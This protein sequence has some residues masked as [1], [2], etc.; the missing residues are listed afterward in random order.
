MAEE[1]KCARC[2]FGDRHVLLLPPLFGWS[3]ETECGGCL[4]ED[5]MPVGAARP[6]FGV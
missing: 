2:G 6:A 4:D 3:V 5:A 1:A